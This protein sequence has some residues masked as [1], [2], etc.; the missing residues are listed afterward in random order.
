MPTEAKARHSR[1]SRVVA[2]G[3]MT[4]S[5]A[6][7]YLRMSEDWIRAAGRK[8]IL[9]TVAIGAAVRYRKEDLDSL[10][11]ANRKAVA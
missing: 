3:L 2:A 8:G 10:I 5:E 7:E 6:G 4:A 1:R 11:Q 9:P